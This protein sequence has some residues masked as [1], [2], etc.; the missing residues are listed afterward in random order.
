MGMVLCCAVFSQ[1]LQ[2]QNVTG[3]KDMMMSFDG[4][5]ASPRSAAMGFT[6]VADGRSV[7]EA[8]TNPA[9]LLGAEG[10]WQTEGGFSTPVFIDKRSRNLYAGLGYRISQKLA[11]AFTV[12]EYKVYHPWLGIV[13][14]FHSYYPNIMS[15]THNTVTLA[16]Q[17]TKKLSVG[18]NG[19]WFRNYFQYLPVQ[20]TWFAD[21]GL[22]YQLFKYQRKTA[23]LANNQKGVD[24]RFVNAGMSFGNINAAASSWYFPDNFKAPVEI[25][26]YFRAGVAGGVSISARK[27][28]FGSASMIPLQSRTIDLNCQLQYLDFFNTKQPNG[29]DVYK[30]GFNAG[31][32]LALLKVVM[33]RTG[34]RFERRVGDASGSNPAIA[35]YNYLKGMTWGM[36]INLPFYLM[37][38]KHLPFAVAL[39][40]YQSKP[41]KWLKGDGPMNTEYATSNCTLS[42]RWYPGNQK[43]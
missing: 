43:K 37:V 40:M 6:A 24:G 31:A 1:M 14:D 34:Y 33:L 15:E 39:D 27:F 9:C 11:V 5:P 19:T 28:V 29:S 30:W 20:K 17:L 10:K 23:D 21:A 41:F 4:Q 16:Y 7:A 13:T 32:E 3:F 25:T 8:R 2:S 36:G 18:M 12:F 35:N 22:L 26:S 42:L 38:K